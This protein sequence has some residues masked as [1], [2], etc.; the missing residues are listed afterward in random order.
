MYDIG[1]ISKAS[2]ALIYMEEIRTTEPMEI[3]ME[4]G[5][6]ISSRNLLIRSDAYI[7]VRNR[8]VLPLNQ[9]KTVNRDMKIL[10]MLRIINTPGG[11]Y[12]CR[13]NPDSS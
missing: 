7:P 13:L 4:K 12:G 6:G 10:K 1:L 5:K 3:L 9:I 8:T 2:I 11:D